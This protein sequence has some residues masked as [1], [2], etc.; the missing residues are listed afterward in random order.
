MKDK[1]TVFIEDINYSFGEVV[2]IYMMITVIMWLSVL[3]I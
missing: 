1:D 3:D 2:G